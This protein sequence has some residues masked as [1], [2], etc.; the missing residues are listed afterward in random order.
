[1]AACFLA[2][3]CTQKQNPDELRRETAHA[4]TA[5]RQD[6]KAVVEGVRDGMKSDKPVNLN[7]ASRSELLD[8]P[9][10]TAER[11]DKIIANRPY[12]NT[13]ELV[14]RHVL[15]GAEYDRIKDRVRVGDK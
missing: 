10:V 13:G 4:T 7:D 12:E 8:L 6:A 5:A 15:S 1:V 3:G 14:S 2:A 11:A 9:G